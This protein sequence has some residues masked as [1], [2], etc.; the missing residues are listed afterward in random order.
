MPYV[1]TNMNS[2]FIRGTRGSHK[3]PR[4]SR[5]KGR[6]LKHIT[7]QQARDRQLKVCQSCA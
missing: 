1:A 7:D 3:D 5:I 6:S 4:C 2:S